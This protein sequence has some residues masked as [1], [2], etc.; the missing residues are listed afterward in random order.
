[1]EGIEKG[2]DSGDFFVSQSL[3]A[4][5]REFLSVDL[6]SDGKRLKIEN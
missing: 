4:G 5:D 6:L 1:L 3:M 2:N